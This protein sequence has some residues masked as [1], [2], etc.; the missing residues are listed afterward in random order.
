M[1]LK[2][3]FETWRG[4]AHRLFGDSA[5]KWVFVCPVC[6]GAQSYELFKEH[7]KLD[8]DRIRSVLHFSC[9]GR[10]AKKIGCDYT[11]GGL[12]NL[13]PVRVFSEGRWT[14]SFAFQGMAELADDPIDTCV[15]LRKLEE[16][17][18]DADVVAWP[19]WVPEAIRKQIADF[20]GCFGR[21][22]KDYFACC[23]DNDAPDFGSEGE[24]RITCDDK[25][26]RGRYI[27]AWNNMG[28]VVLPDGQ[29]HAT[30]I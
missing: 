22:P 26:V 14:S 4:E 1:T 16:A 27:H 15:E 11:S 17:T 18:G 7:T 23:R 2:I 25:R 10:Y 8:D 28:R 30:S 12:L 24:F 19:D 20:W 3:T 9:I 5:K 13:A 21:K 6:K 29:H